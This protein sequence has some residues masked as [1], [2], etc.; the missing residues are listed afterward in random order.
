M[1]RYLVGRRPAISSLPAVVGVAFLLRDRV[2]TIFVLTAVSFAVITFIVPVIVRGVAPNL[3]GQLLY[4][5]SRYS[6]T[7]VLLLWS[8][9]LAEAI[10]LSRITQRRV[11]RYV[12]ALACLIV[13]VPVW[14]LDFRPANLRTGGPAWN[15][16]VSAAFTTCDAH[17]RREA[18]L[19]ISPPGWK[20]VLPCDDVSK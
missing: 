19:Q 5:G 20:V 7:P 14:V 17:P 15:E 10:Q 4:V 3:V 18:I 11:T 8:A 1:L 9:V 6:A 12:P 16:Q 2:T 13:L